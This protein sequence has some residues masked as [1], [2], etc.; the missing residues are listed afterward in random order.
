MEA[1]A[2]RHALLS[3]AI[4]YCTL[5]TLSRSRYALPRTKLADCLRS[6]HGTCFLLEGKQTMSRWILVFALMIAV[7]STVSPHAFAAGLR[8]DD[9]GRD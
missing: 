5:S 3:P 9:N 8:I 1:T 6:A 7:V 2:T 4:Y